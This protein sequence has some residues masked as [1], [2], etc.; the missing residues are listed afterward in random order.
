M[1]GLREP[2]EP[3]G[4]YRA[5]AL[6]W[7]GGVVT[8]FA[9]NARPAMPGTMNSMKPAKLKRLWLLVLTMAIRISYRHDCLGPL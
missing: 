2:S 4:S 1:F 7:A 8:L 6:A 5:C 3:P 9:I